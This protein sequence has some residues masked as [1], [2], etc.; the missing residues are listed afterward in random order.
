MNTDATAK[1]FHP[2]ASRHR[3][4]GGRLALGWKPLA[5]ASVFIDPPP[6]LNLLRRRT[7]IKPFS[8]G[9]AR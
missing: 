8:R 3:I 9:C 5:A 4:P 1:G 7:R 2:R 6:Y